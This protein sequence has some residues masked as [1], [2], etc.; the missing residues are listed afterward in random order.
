MENLPTQ[1]FLYGLAL[2]VGVLTF[3]V[4]YLVTLYRKTVSEVYNLK[5]ADR[6]KLSDEITKRADKVITLMST[7]L[8]KRFKG[9]LE[10]TIDDSKVLLA[11][12]IHNVTA[13]IGEDMAAQ[14]ADVG[15]IMRESTLGV[16][17]AVRKV[18]EEKYAQVEKEIEDYKA[19]EYGEI[20]TKAKE[21]LSKVL[22]TTITKAANMDPGKLVMETLED[23]KR[24]NLL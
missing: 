10:S 18:V 23:A 13:Q 16:Q 21:I 3:T 17:E 7:D 15:K 19:K 1:I 22:T 2:S 14:V 24:Q 20:E 11:S 6:I 5:K 4:A 12:Q 8:E 9:E